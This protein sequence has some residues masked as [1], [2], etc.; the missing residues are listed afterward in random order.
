MDDDEFPLFSDT[1]WREP[2]IAEFPLRKLPIIFIANI[3]SDLDA[4]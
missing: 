3:A 2:E 4:Q 1:T